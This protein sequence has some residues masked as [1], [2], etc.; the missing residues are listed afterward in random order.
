MVCE[1]TS[2][3]LSHE[4]GRGYEAAR[5][6]VCECQDDGYSLTCS[7]TACPSCNLDGTICALSTDYG[8]TW[9]DHMVE[10]GWHVT[11]QY[12]VGRND[13]VSFHERKH[14]DPFGDTCHVFVN[15]Q[16][17][18]SCEDVQCDDGYKGVRVMCDNLEG[19]GN[20]DICDDNFDDG[21]LTALALQDPLLLGGGGC[22][23]RLDTRIW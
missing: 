1:G 15:G 17:C 2:F 20:L 8:P 13:T 23:P 10:S 22:A 14:T 16:E 3:D 18:R 19:V 21:V 12:V 6:T 4:H 7:D 9:D 5:G 11:F